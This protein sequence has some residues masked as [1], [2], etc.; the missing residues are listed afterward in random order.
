MPSVFVCL[1]AWFAV[2][3]VMITDPV[4]NQLTVPSHTTRATT[5]HSNMSENDLDLPNSPRLQ[6]EDQ[7]VTCWPSH[8]MWTKWTLWLYVVCAWPYTPAQAIYIPLALSRTGWQTHWAPVYM[9]FEHVRL[10]LLSC[11]RPASA[12][13]EAFLSVGQYEHSTSLSQDAFDRVRRFFWLPHRSRR[14]AFY[15][16]HH[17]SEKMAPGN[18][19]L[20]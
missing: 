19:I 13:E 16:V 3:E 11:N 9:L 12:Q 5:K 15:R 1:S 7:D 6:W 18:S 17:F 14:V 4:T 10:P 8:I 20:V 2:N